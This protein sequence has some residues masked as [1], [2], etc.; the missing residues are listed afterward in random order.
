LYV[1]AEDGVGFTAAWTSHEGELL[2]TLDEISA[3]LAQL[4][5]DERKRA[6]E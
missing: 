4:H 3:R 6:S 2:W 5:H 1:P